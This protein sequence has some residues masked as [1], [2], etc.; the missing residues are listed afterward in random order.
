M[1]SVRFTQGLT[2]PFSSSRKTSSG[3]SVILLCRLQY[4]AKARRVWGSARSAIHRMPLMVL[5]ASLPAWRSTQVMKVL[6]R[7]PVLVAFHLGMSARMYV[8]D[9]QGM[10]IFLRTSFG[11]AL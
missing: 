4:A 11:R 3:K 5:L 1:L 10:M 8:S 6:Y 7:F 9:D 2:A